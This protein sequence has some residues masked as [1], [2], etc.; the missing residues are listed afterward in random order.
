L[1]KNGGAF[2]GAIAIAH[3]G[4]ALIS[5]VQS[6]PQLFDR[7]RAHARR[8]GLDHFMVG[9]TVSADLTALVRA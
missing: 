8:S 2:S 5:E 6:G 7:S 3:L 9:T 4:D 1:P